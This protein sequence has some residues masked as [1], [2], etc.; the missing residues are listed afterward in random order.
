MN[1]DERFSHE[2]L[3]RLS[4]VE[5]SA[6]LR[7]MVAQIPL[8]HPREA[9]SFW[10][11]GSLWAPSFA[12]AAAAL[13][14]LFVGSQSAG[15]PT[16]GSTASLSS[17]ETSIAL[18]DEDLDDLIMMATSAHFSPDEWDLFMTSAHNENTEEPY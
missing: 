6:D 17:D 2:A 5:P 16:T 14:G 10:P 13:L 11:F 3:S 9:R 8:R 15:A 18:D 7:R 12:L 1:D 4:P